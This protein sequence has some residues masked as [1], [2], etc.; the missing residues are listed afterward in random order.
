MLLDRRSKLIEDLDIVIVQLQKLLLIKNLQ[1]EALESNNFSELYEFAEN[2]R[3]IIEEINTSMRI[4]IGD[5]V[6]FKK[7]PVIKKKIDMIDSLQ[8]KVIKINISLKDGLDK[9]IL[10]TEKKLTS[11][12]QFNPPINQ[13]RPSIINIRA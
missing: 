13:G 2:E 5:L 3:I 7:D 4:L 10:R 8:A 11:L 1:D 9:K 6:A 12:N